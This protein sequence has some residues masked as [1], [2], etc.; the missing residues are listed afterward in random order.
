MKSLPLVFVLPI[1]LNLVISPYSIVSGARMYRAY[2]CLVYLE[3]R[4]PPLLSLRRVQP[5]PRLHQRG[6]RRPHVG[7]RGLLL[8]R[9]GGARELAVDVRAE[10]PK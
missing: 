3:R 7:R 5:R 1:V 10:G 6:E 8:G 2:L 4:D 9:E